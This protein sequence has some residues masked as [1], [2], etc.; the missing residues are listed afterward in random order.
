[1]DDFNT[2]YR[3]K[4]ST[5]NSLAAKAHNFK[6]GLLLLAQ[7][8]PTCGHPGECSLFCRRCKFGLSTSTTKTKIEESNVGGEKIDNPAYPKAVEEYN[9]WKASAANGVVTSQKEFLLF[10]KWKN[11]PF[12]KIFPNSKVPNGA[13]IKQGVPST[14]ICPFTLHCLDQSQV[15][16]IYVEKYG[17]RR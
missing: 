1:M 14:N 5:T 16:D 9:N 4:L 10:K 2:Y 11:F 8:C 7:V 17:G 3:N 13:Q 12:K 6:M 15:L